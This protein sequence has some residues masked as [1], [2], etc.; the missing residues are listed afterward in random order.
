V[1]PNDY[2]ISV[3]K[4]DTH[5]TNLKELVNSKFDVD[6]VLKSYQGSVSLIIN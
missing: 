5:F 6:L 4:L 2:D 3:N 1:W